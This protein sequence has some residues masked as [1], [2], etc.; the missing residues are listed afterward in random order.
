LHPEKFLD[1]N[2][3]WF[4]MKNGSCKNGD[5]CRRKHI[6]LKSGEVCPPFPS[7]TVVIKSSKGL[8][9]RLGTGPVKGCLNCGVMGHWPSECEWPC[10]AFVRGRC[11]NSEC[12]F[13]HKIPEPRNLPVCQEYKNY[14]TCRRK[15]CDKGHYSRIQCIKFLEGKCIHG[16]EC[17]S[18]HLSF[19]SKGQE[20]E[21]MKTTFSESE[22]CKDFQKKCQA[23]KS[24]SKIH[25]KLL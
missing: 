2:Y 13:K 24:C 12:K 15:E 1:P 25:F 3:C 11:P 9:P 18:L 17:R 4:F 5:Q 14:G 23:G 10:T 21:G 16:N 7:K 19:D 22:V 20:E 6:A 8:P